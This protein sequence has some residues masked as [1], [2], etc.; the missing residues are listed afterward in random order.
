MAHYNVPGVSVAVIENGQLA[1]AKG[2]G[3]REAGTDDEVDA[4]TVFSVAS[5]SKVATAAATLR[6]TANGAVELDRDVNDYLESWTLPQSA[7]TRT[8]P[9]TLRGLMSHT[10]GTSVHGFPDFQPAAPLPTVIDT[11]DG[12]P[13][14]KTDP[15]RVVY[16]PGTGS[17]Y[18]GGGIT[19]EQL[20]IADIT[21]RDFPAALNDLVLGPL[22]MKR[23]TFRNPLPAEFGNIAKAHEQDGRVTALPRGWHSFPE[24][25]A[26]GLWTTP[27]D[28]GK[29]IVALSDSY[30]GQAGAFLPRDLARQMMTEVGMS[31][32]GLGVQLTG[33]GLTRRFFHS[34]SNESY[35]AW[36]EGHPGL[37]SGFAV[38]TNGA[39]GMRLYFEIR[40][41]LAD[42]HDWP[43]Y[44]PVRRPEIG[45]TEE[46]RAS[47]AGT[48]HIRHPLPE[49]QQRMLV[50]THFEGFR[51]FE[52][53]GELFL[54]P[55]GEEDSFRLVP[56]SPTKFLIEDN[57]AG[58]PSML[59]AEFIRATDGGI[60]GLMLH[61][62]HYAVVA[63]RCDS[64][65]RRC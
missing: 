47:L 60:S 31:Y 17:S 34:G 27:T 54:A 35:R 25:A 42:A 15:V 41:A 26:S 9:V 19:V 55:A 12:R 24:M 43:F 50:I 37:D 33:E 7:L 18:S 5:I 11:L 52:R 30:N 51:V 10:A 59:R 65:Y 29:L 4:E 13:P 45:L 49:P 28:L 53:E 21:D 61:R 32:F 14:A 2:Y 23:S 38:V 56:T 48:Y 16:T 20:L 6:L 44:R 36:M 1:W 3:L 46:E 63:Y 39:D 57:Y 40:R 62:D 22:G 58:T 8:A 64:E